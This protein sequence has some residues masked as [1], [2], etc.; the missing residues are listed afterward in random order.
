LTVLP[1]YA[2][3]LYVQLVAT[4]LTATKMFHIAPGVYSQYF[5]LY[6]PRIDVLYSVIKVLVFITIITFVHCAYGFNAKGGPEDVG[7]AAGRA[8]RLSVTLIFLVNFLLSLMFFSHVSSV[9]FS[10]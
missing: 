5:N 6:L 8:V 7:R 3:G 2:I 10:G 4:Q 1:L 9:R